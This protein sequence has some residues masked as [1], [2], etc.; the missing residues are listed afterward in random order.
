M[1]TTILNGYFGGFYVSDTNNIPKNNEICTV[2]YLDN[3]YRAKW[4]G[5]E[6]VEGA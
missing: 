2:P 5:T 3:Y 6:W 1:N 4:N